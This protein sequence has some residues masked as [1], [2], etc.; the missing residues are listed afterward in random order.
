MRR[1]HITE[2]SY[3]DW[4]K[5]LGCVFYAP[6]RQNDYM[7]YISGTT[8]TITGDGSLVWNSTAQM[9]RFTSPTTQLRGVLQYDVNFD[10]GDDDVVVLAKIKRQDSGDGNLNDALCF[11]GNTVKLFSGINGKNSSNSP[12]TV[13][14]LWSS[15][16][17]LY[18]GTLFMKSGVGN[19]FFENGSMYYTNNYNYFSSYGLPST[20]TK[21][22]IAGSLSSAQSGSYYR[23]NGANYFISDYMLFNKGLDINTINEITAKSD[24]FLR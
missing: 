20:I 11:S 13:M 3:I 5:S 7:D 12:T 22:L 19:S 24:L 15:N 9:Y 8:G 2:Q 17:A 23:Y 4:L 16:N 10:L 1:E 21:V 14:R 6:L 18:R